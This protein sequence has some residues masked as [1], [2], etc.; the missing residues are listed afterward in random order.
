MKWSTFPKQFFNKI[1]A[2]LYY[3]SLNTQNLKKKMSNK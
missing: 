3:K 1:S 2:H